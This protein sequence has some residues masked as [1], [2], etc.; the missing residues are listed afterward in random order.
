MAVPGLGQLAL[1]GIC[2]NLDDAIPALSELFLKLQRLLAARPSP[3]M[4]S[5]LAEQRRTIR[6]LRAFSDFV[7]QSCCNPALKNAI[8]GY[9]L[10]NALRI[11]QLCDGVRHPEL[12]TLRTITESQSSVMRRSDSGWGDSGSG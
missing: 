8:G 7:S 11:D 3:D 1:H 5:V 10:D 6:V 2:T 4:D 12:R 9:L